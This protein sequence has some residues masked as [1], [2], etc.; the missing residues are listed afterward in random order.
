MTTIEGNDMP[1]EAKSY[2]ATQIVH[3]P[4]GPV[5]ACDEH[6]AQLKALFGLLGGHIVAT[7]LTAP[8]ECTNCV[9]EEVD[10]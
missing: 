7:T 8:E 6:A 3:C 4:S 2:P 10:S 5:A 9:N 1:N